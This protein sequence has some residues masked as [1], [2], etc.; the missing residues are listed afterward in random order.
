MKYDCRK[1]INSRKLFRGVPLWCSKHNDYFMSAIEQCKGNSYNIVESIE[2]HCGSDIE[3]EFINE[4]YIY[5]C[6]K[7]KSCYTLDKVDTGF[8][9]RPINP[10]LTKERVKLD[11]EN[12]FASI[13]IKRNEKGERVLEINHYKDTEEFSIS[14]KLYKLLKEELSG[15]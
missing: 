11:Y 5:Q 8:K 10:I 6:E 4:T 7:C 3:V 2:C 9:I 1:C 13:Y 14:A 12:R 15:L